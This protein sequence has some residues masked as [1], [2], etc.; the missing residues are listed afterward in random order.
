MHVPA[1]PQGKRHYTY[2][3]GGKDTAAAAPA[4]S[5]E[6]TYPSPGLYYRWAEGG[7]GGFR[8]G[9]DPGRGVYPWH[10]W[11]RAA[12]PQYPLGALS[13]RP[14]LG[15]GRPGPLAT[16]RQWVGQWQGPARE[17][18]LGVL[19]APRAIGS[20]LGG[21][22]RPLRDRDLCFLLRGRALPPSVTANRRRLESNRRRLE[23]NRRHL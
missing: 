1:V 7:V 9:M 16:S 4:A 10:P 8:G 11:S 6:P 20:Y 23:A 18:R 22:G 21:P 19:G 14:G 2:Y 3:C 17:G 15:E 5:S 13:A 12:F